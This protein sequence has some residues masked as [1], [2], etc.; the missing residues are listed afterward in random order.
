MSFRE[1]LLQKRE[2]VTASNCTIFCGNP[3]Y[4]FKFQQTFFDFC[5]LQDCYFFVNLYNYAIKTNRILSMNIFKN[6]KFFNDAN[7]L[8]HYTHNAIEGP[9]LATEFISF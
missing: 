2:R 8:N 3:R 9:T 5:D 6:T 7:T 4:V 1:T